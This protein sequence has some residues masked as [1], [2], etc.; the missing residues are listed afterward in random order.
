[1]KTIKQI[2][3]AKSNFAKVGLEIKEQEKLWFDFWKSSKNRKAFQKQI[4]EHIE[5][6]VE[7]QNK[8]SED[9]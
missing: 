2:S 7:R 1:M 6:D 4:E 3:E 9:P 8:K 5:Y